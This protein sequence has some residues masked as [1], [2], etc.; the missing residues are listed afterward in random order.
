M[1]LVILQS[2]FFFLPSYLGNAAPVILAH[3]KI[4]ERLAV[5][6]DGGRRLWGEPA[7]GATKTWRGILGGALFGC[8]TGLLQAWLWQWS[9]DAGFLFLTEYSWSFGALLGLLLGL[10]EGIGDLIKSFFK[11]RLHI[12]STAAFFPFDQLSFIGALLFSALVFIPSVQHL[13]V[14]CIASIVI[15]VI[16][17][18]AAFRLGWKKV[19]W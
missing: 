16:S 9:P 1:V 4:A 13:I 7:F 8:L 12:K 14:I 11:R 17:N 10:G 6:V 19:P 2:L 18:Y 3:F 15:P 5:P